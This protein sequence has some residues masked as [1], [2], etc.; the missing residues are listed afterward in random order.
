MFARECRNSIRAGNRPCGQSATDAQFHD[1]IEVPVE[2][3]YPFKA[4]R[5]KRL[6]EFGIPKKKQYRSEQVASALG[7]STDLLRWRFRKGK[8]EEVSKDSAG[9]RIF[10]IRDI[11]R[12]ANIPLRRSHG[13]GRKK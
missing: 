7:I 3:D 12:L 10:S 2:T 1:S 13:S 9:R 11:Q 8:Y 6:N 5:P 4:L